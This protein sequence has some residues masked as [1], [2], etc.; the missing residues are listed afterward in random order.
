MLN[1]ILLTGALLLLAACASTT[2][3]PEPTAAVGTSQL[4]IP[5]QAL[6]EAAAAQPVDR[7]A[8]SDVIDITVFQVPDLTRTVRVN[9]AGEISLPLIGAMPAAGKTVEE[10]ET[11]IARRLGEKYMR[12][13]N[14]TVFI[15]E[16]HDVPVKR[17][18]V[19]GA[20]K[21]PGVYDIKGTTTLLQAI[22]LARGVEE[23]AN[24][25]GVVVFRTVNK[26]RMAARFDLSAIRKGMA[27]DPELFP[28]D[29]VVVDQTDGQGRAIMRAILQS[30]PII[31]VF[32]PF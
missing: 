24:L 16:K 30:L 10:V 29:I 14:V 3:P 23:T 13:P 31:S 5:V 4:P 20:V 15:K 22:A 18:T 2:P 8:P 9:L 12:S 11:E 21:Q 6:Q 28:E 25:K 19:E 17:L 32:R 27:P 26:Q 1:R 7:L